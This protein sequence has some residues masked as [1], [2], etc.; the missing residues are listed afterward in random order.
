MPN[1]S[2]CLV[3]A[4][5]SV[6]ALC[7]CPASFAEALPA[8]THQAYAASVYN[9]Q[10]GASFGSYTDPSS[11]DVSYAGM[12]FFGPALVALALSGR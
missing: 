2:A 9:W 6:L 12:S 1:L 10:H 5:G 7:A 11:G 3:R 8:P 4:A